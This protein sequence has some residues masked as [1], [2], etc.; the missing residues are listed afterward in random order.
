MALVASEQNFAQALLKPD[1][2]L[3]LLEEG[4]QSRDAKRTLQLWEYCLVLEVGCGILELEFD[5]VSLSQQ[6]DADVQ[7]PKIPKENEVKL[8]D[9]TRLHSEE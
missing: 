5:D 2:V 8:V 9:G 4:F 7:V 6:A 1:E 3:A